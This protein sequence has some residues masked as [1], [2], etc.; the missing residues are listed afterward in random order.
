MTCNVIKS[1]RISIFELWVP[2]AH[3]QGPIGIWIS[4]EH[5]GLWLTAVK[6][7]VLDYLLFPKV[8]E[9]DQKC[10]WIK[11]FIRLRWNQAASL[12]AKH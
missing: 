2:S 4:A 10:M 1:T 8:N 9:P 7:V 12:R 11:S 6:L 3:F 5:K